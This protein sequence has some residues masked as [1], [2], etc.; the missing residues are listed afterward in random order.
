[1]TKPLTV[2]LTADDIKPGR[3]YEAKKPMTVGFYRELNDR[4]VK[5]VD[6]LR[7]QYDSPT[8]RDGQGYP[9]ISMEKF[10]KW[11]GRD[12]TELMPDCDWRRKP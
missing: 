10:L 4:Q 6:P 1:M 2:A 12:V 11:A 7:V 8:V 9:I 5:W 3:C